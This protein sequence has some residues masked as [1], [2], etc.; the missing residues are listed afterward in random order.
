MVVPETK[1]KYGRYVVSSQRST[2]FNSTAFPFWCLYLFYFLSTAMHKMFIEL[3]DEFYLLF[4]EFL[5]TKKLP[6]KV[7]TFRKSW[8]CCILKTREYQV[9]S[10]NFWSNSSM[11]RSPSGD[12]D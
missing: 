8:M 1:K 10:I 11:G 2:Q 3:K 12:K 4:S 6:G 7:Y 5:G 9:L